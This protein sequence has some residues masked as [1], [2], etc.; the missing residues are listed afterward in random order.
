MS[1]VFFMKDEKNIKGFEKQIDL[2]EGED[3]K[4]L[5]KAYEDGDTIR[6]RFMP[7][8]QVCILENGKLR[9]F[10]W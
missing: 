6:N 4:K 2:C 5:K 8:K 1:A 3:S 9:C 7:D 10:D